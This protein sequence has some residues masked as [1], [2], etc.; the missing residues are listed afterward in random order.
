[1]KRCAYK[2]FLFFLLIAFVP[3]FIFADDEINEE[4]ILFENIS[5]E[6]SSNTSDIPILNARHAIL[7]DR[8]SKTFIYG[9][10]E[11]EKCKMASTTKVMTAIIVIENSDLKDIV[12]ISSNSARTGG[13]RLGLCKK[14]KISVNDLLYGLMLKSGNDDSVSY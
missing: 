5:I 11:D 14:D 12:E 9:K 13:S 3:T 1:M 6:T 8:T 4:N 2:L 7:F 10:K